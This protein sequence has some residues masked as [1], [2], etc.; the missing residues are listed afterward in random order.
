MSCAT[1][2]RLIRKALFILLL[3]SSPFGAFGLAADSPA[4][5]YRSGEKIIGMI[6]RVFELTNEKERQRAVRMLLDTVAREGRIPITDSSVYFIYAGSARHVFVAGDFNAWSP[7]SDGMMHVQGTNLFVLNLVLPHAARFEYKFVVDSNWVLDS[8]N[9]RTALGGFGSNSE[10]SLPGYLPPPDTGYRGNVQHGTIDTLEFQSRLLGCSHPVLV[11]LPP[12]HTPD[13]AMR[14][15]YVTDGGEYLERTRFANVL[16]NLIAGHRI[17]PLAGIFVDPRLRLDDSRTNRRMSEYAI[18]DT[19]LNFLADELRPFLAKSY[20]ITTEPS[21]TG[22]LGASMGGLISTYA[23]FRRPDA[24]GLG[25]A[26]SPAYQIRGETIFS[27]IPP[28]NHSGVKMY[29]ETGTLHDAEIL[30][31][32]MKDALTRAGFLVRYVEVPEGHNWI[33]WS[34]HLADLLTYFWGTP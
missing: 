23:I 16:D 9:P 24:F 27:K 20:H 8:L 29:L 21:H 12:G 19:F 2:P 5:Q 4:G 33:N 13:T 10:V 25:A 26:Q 15:L 30:S 22:I 32:R 3:I 18:S 6:H 7:S 11:Y 28:G 34:G 17:P 31:R 1:S 14:V